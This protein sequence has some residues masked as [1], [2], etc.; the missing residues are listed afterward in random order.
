MNIGQHSPL[1]KSAR[2]LM[3]D[4]NRHGLAAR[5]AI[6]ESHGYTVIAKQCPKMALQCVESEEFDLL[7]TDFRM[8][9]VDGL[10][11]IRALR[12][13]RP[14]VPV[15]LLSS[16]ADPLGLDQASTGAD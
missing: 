8:P 14:E 12:G 15:I 6:L 9:H 7:I 1:K 16:V 4:D 11:I 5:R 2:I 10:Q 3:V 13:L